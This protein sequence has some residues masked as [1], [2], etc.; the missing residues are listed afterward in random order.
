MHSG[1]GLHLSIC[2]AIRISGLFDQQAP[3]PPA[4]ASG[5]LRYEHEAL[6]KAFVHGHLSQARDPTTCSRSAWPL[7]HLT[8]YLHAP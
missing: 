8:D 1:P 2:L 5:D 7:V 6:Y 4:S 3:D